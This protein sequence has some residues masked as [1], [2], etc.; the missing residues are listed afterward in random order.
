MAP[1]E[2]EAST[3]NTREPEAMERALPSGRRLALRIGSAGEEIE[4][5]SPAGDVEVRI[6]LTDA[7][8]VVSLRAARLELNAADAV[9]VR[10]RDFGVEASGEIKLEANEV[11]AQTEGDIHLNGAFIRL[12]C[13]PEGEVA[14]QA[15]L[16][17]ARAAMQ[18]AEGALEASPPADPCG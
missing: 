11:R 15:L 10:C 1:R 5:R 6:A 17:K 3:T 18:A 8:P 2:T 14:A 13:T 4:I 16:A 7:G 12:N 9:A